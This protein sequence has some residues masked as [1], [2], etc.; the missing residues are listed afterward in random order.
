MQDSVSCKPQKRW[1]S[2]IS[3]ALLDTRRSG[4][5]DAT[6]QGKRESLRQL[7]KSLRNDHG[8]RWIAKCGETGNAAGIGNNRTPYQVIMNPGPQRLRNLTIY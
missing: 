8:Q 3:F 6:Y 4:P 1:I 5:S 2:L 7:T